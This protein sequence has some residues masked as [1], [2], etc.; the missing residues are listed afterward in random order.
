MVTE[1]RKNKVSYI[2]VENNGLFMATNVSILSGK[3]GIRLFR[4]SSK[5][6]IGTSC[7]PFL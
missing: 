1:R 2:L 4:I 3:C 5:T 7:I 6:Y